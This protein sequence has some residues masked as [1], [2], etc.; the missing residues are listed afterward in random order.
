MWSSAV[1]R[2]RRLLARV[3]GA[4]VRAL[5]DEILDA[6]LLT[7]RLLI[8]Q[9]HAGGVVARLSD[10]EWRVFSQFGDDGII[11]YLI[12]Q[13]GIPP[14]SRRF[15]EF[16]VQD[17][18]ESNTRFLLFNDNWRGLILDGDAAN[19][20]SVAASSY[21]W[22][23]E[24][25]AVAAFVD[26]ENVNQLFTTHGFAGEV[27]VLSI[28]IDGNDYWVW[29]RI[30]VVDPIIVIVE[31]NSTFGARQALSVP[32]DPGFRRG[33]AHYSNLYWGAGL[34]SLCSLGAA[35]GYGFV[36]CNSA[37]NNAY[38][39]RRDRLGAL[40]VLD[41]VAGFVVARFRE[42]R[43]ARGRLSYLRG[44][45]RLREIRTLPLEDVETGRIQTIAEW[46]GV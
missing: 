17:Y 29:Q 21:Y 42:S 38:F 27:G 36:G 14:E 45:E 41:A 31:F 5:R 1:G 22:R 6:K 34:K 19:I 24:L 23:H 35:K 46:F 9:M 8:Q 37:G 25:S 43:D 11:Q 33:R 12:H 18:S 40:P 2:L 16:G 20:A 13:V 28:D 44:D 39:V 15:I 32:Y 3:L 7:A 26:R 30:D 4:D 10:A